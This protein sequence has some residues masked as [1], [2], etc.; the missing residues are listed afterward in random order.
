MEA[1]SLWLQ[2]AGEYDEDLPFGMGQ[3]RLRLGFAFNNAELLPAEEQS[4]GLS[5]L[6][7]FGST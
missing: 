4:A 5:H 3:V 6:A 1:L 7:Q 2:A